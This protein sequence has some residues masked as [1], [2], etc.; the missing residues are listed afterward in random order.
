[1][2]SNERYKNEFKEEFK[3]EFKNKFTKKIKYGIG[4]LIAGTFMFAIMGFAT[5][6]LWNWLIPAVFN[7]GTVTFWQAIGLLALGKLLTGFG[8]MGNHSWKG[9]HGWKGHGMYDRSY[10]KNR[11]EQ[12]MQHM[13]PEEKEKFKN[14]YYDRCGWRLSDKDTKG[15][16]SKLTEESV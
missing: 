16:D 5:M 9:K 15:T 12:K 1:M 13:T 10:W 3:A 6:F 14:Y 11:M 4:W 8:G 2:E 7:G